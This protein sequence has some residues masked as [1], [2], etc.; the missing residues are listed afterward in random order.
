PEIVDLTGKLTLLESAAV[1]RQCDRLITNDTGLMHMAEAVKT[2]VTAIFGST[3][4]QLGFF[5]FLE[6]SHVVENL[7]VSCRPCSHV[8]RKNCPKGHFQCMNSIH[9]EMVLDK[10]LK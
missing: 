4:R 7:T 5:P 10:V 2:P 1:L 6:R 8:G 3:V 9:P